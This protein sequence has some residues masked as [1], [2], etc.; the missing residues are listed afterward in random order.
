MNARIEELTKLTL[1]GDMAQML[2]RMKTQD[3]RL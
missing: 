3:L 2:K 1:K